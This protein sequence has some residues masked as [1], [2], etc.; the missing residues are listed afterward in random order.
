MDVQF[1]FYILGK[2]EFFWAG[3][4]HFVGNL[5]VLYSYADPVAGAV[6]GSQV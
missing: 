1:F 2:Q 5:N 6:C 3:M 4:L